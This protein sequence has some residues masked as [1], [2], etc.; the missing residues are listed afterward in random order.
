MKKPYVVINCA[1]SADGKIALPNRKQMRISCDEDIKRMYHLRNESDA[2]LVGIG[3][4][5]TDDPKLT[6]KEEYVKNPKQPLRLILDYY[7][8]TPKNALALNN[9]SKTIILS[10]KGN[11]KQYNLENVK[12]IGCKTVG[13]GLLDLDA[14]LDILCQNKIRKVLVEGGSTVIWNFLKER[15]ADELFIYVGP[16]IIGGKNTPTVAD[17]EGIKNRDDV[18]SLKII[19]IKKFG[20]GLLIQ[21]KPI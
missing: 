1:M 15:L 16:F 8:K 17:G 10:K 21:Y 2:V 3:T 18:I 6:I 12:V 19:K 13:P 5:L 9:T 7:C 14:I 11:E 4:I 20:P